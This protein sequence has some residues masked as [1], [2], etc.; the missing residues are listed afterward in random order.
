MQ[1]N[2]TKQLMREPSNSIRSIDNATCSC[3]I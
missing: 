1:K 2:A 3:G